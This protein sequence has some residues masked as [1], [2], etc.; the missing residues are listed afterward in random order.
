MPAMDRR[1]KPDMAGLACERLQSRG[2]SGT[3]SG[4]LNSTVPWVVPVEQGATL[5]A[6]N[7]SGNPR[8][9]AAARLGGR[10]DVRVL[11]PSPP[12]VNE[13]PWFADDPVNAANGPA[14]LPIVSP[15]PGGD[16]LWAE[17]AEGDLQHWCR[18]RWLIPGRLA[19]APATLAGTRLALHRL[20]EH[21]ISPARRAANGKIGLRYTRGGFGT[22]FFGEDVQV[23]VF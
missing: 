17:L 22:P 14:G 20:A 16:L 8:A 21:V 11:E 2:G 15:V 19:P 3:R 1:P 13:E 23:R 9:E 10:Y 18:E 4:G 7:T 12:A 6:L 5:C